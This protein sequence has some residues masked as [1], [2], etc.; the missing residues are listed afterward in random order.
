MRQPLSAVFTLAFVA[1]AFAGDGPGAKQI[2]EAYGIQGFHQI[3]S[4]SFTFNVEKDGKQMVS[5]AWTWEPKTGKV[6]YSGPDKAGKPIQATYNR[7][8]EAKANEE[9]EQ[10]FINDSYWFLFP[11]HLVWD[12]N[13]EITQDGMK[14]MP[15]PPGEGHC[16]TVHYTGGGFT[17]GDVYKLYVTPD[18][19]VSQWT[20][21]GGGKGDERPFT[22][23]DHRKLGPIVVALE[24]KGPGG[25][26]RL[27]FS[28]VSATVG[29]KTVTPQ[30]M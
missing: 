8:T 24:H 7:N 12:T 25:K 17:P 9:L 23:E 13:V 18:N 26:F 2:A 27:W 14:P 28:D 3:D 30:A 22:W 21:Q 5:R 6:G 16:V 11:M 10:G 4:L 1:M 15:M 19:H 20:F 29:G